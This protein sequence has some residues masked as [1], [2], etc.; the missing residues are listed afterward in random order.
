MTISWFQKADLKLKSRLQMVWITFGRNKFTESIT[1]ITSRQDSVKLA[2]NI[3][4]R[5]F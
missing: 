2:E 1:P 5:N 3:E 4:F